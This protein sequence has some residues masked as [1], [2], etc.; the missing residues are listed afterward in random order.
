MAASHF[1]YFMGGQPVSRFC[2]HS[3]F[4]IFVIIYRTPNK[5]PEPTRLALSVWRVRFGIHGVV[6]L[7]WL[8]F[9]R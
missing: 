1:H 6:V 7:A 5:T 8:S 3:P 4:H 2:L 9:F